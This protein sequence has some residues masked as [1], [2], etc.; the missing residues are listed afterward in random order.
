[1]DNLPLWS[2]FALSL[3]QGV[4]EFLPVSSSAHLILFPAVTGLPDQGLAI[5]VATHAGT[6]FAV[7]VAFRTETGRLFSGGLRLLRGRTDHADT[8]LVLKIAA[9]TVPVVIVGLL[10]KDIIATEFR[11][12]V[13]IAGSSALFAAVLWWA[14]RTPGGLRLDDLGWRIVMV[15]GLCQ[16]IALIPGVSR[17]GITITAALFCGA[18]RTDAA[19]FSLLLAIP[20][21]TAAGVLLSIDLFAEGTTTLWSDALLVAGLSFVSAW[22]AILVMMRWLQQTGFTVFV[23]YRLVLSG[24]LVLSLMTGVL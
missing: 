22:G 4:T 17:A 19:R 14:D 13:V 7:L 11:S 9:A 20:T 3:I 18:C 10:F 5:D 21:T 1:M 23:L 16:A 2:L 15:I 8:E 12:P 24:V 6:L